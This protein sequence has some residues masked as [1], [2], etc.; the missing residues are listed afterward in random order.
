MRVLVIGEEP[1]KRTKNNPTIRNLYKWLDYL[2]LHI[3]SFA[4]I[5]DP[6]LK[7][8]V[9]NY[10]AIITLG[11]KASIWINHYSDYAMPHCALPHPSPRNRQ[12]ND[13]KAI[14][15][16]L[17]DCIYFLRRRRDLFYRP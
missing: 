5:S 8:Y 9:H 11:R 7:Y 3:V 10:P 6:D 14:E 1:S 12:L 2:D 4:N 16:F 17:N 15:A 13:K